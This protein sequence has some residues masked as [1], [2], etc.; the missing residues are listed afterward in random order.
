MEFAVVLFTI[1]VSLVSLAPAGPVYSNSALRPRNFVPEHMVWVSNANQTQSP[2]APN[3][4]SVKACQRTTY[5]SGTP[6]TGI[7]RSDCQNLVSQLKADPGYWEMWW[8][9]KTSGYKTLT[10]NGTCNFAV[11]RSDGQASAPNLASDVAIIGNSD[12]VEVLNHILSYGSGEDVNSNNIAGEMKCKW[13]FANNTT[14]GF[15][16]RNNDAVRET[17]TERPRGLTLAPYDAPNDEVHAARSH[18]GLFGRLPLEIPPAGPHGGLREPHAAHQPAPRAPARP[19][20]AAVHDG[21]GGGA[22]AGAEAPVG[23]PRGQAAELGG[24]E[25]QEIAAAAAGP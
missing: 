14:M 13:D 21:G 6:A 1:L 19:P 9:D 23:G 25:G 11:S 7:R 10:T 22:A 5:H 12:V 20:P 24:G 15:V 2:W 18:Y 8:W 17:G 16:V 3:V 4:G